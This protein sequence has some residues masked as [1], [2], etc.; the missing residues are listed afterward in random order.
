M[1]RNT[2]S[3]TTPPSPD[4]ANSDRKHGPLRYFTR[5]TRR[6]LLTGVAGGAITLATHLPS[7][8]EAAAQH[9]GPPE[10]QYKIAEQDGIVTD[11]LGTHFVKA[12]DYIVLESPAKACLQPAGG[13]KAGPLNTAGQCGV[14]SYYPGFNVTYLSENWYTLNCAMP[15]RGQVRPLTLSSRATTFPSTSRTQPTKGSSSA[16]AGATATAAVSGSG[17]RDRS[18]AGSGQAER[19]IPSGTGAVDG[20]VA[21][22][23]S[24]IGAT[25]DPFV[26]AKRC[27]LEEAVL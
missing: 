26:D 19:R 21:P 17:H 24:F 7:G 1:K 12:G 25:S 4:P 8:S 9:C 3:Q 22:M 14:D 2:T 11:A 13:D 5:L 18:A 16:K 15:A 20:R 6:S 10:S 27:I 23:I